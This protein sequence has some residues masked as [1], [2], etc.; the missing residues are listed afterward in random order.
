[1]SSLQK[2]I[3]QLMEDRG[4][5][6]R[7]AELPVLTRF[8]SRLRERSNHEHHALLD[9]FAE[10]VTIFDRV[11]YGLHEV[12]TDALDRFQANFEKIKTC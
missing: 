8:L 1:M 2:A 7:G 6:P 11:W 4:R 10:N 12:T 9:A 5:E 3:A